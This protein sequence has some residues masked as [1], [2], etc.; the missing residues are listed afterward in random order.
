MIHDT[1]LG[2][3]CVPKPECVHEHEHAGGIGPGVHVHLVLAGNGQRTAWA[4]P[5][6]KSAFKLGFC[7][8]I[9]TPTR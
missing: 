2:P 1:P 5:T 7:P 4:R 8:Y 6:V 9:S 3:R